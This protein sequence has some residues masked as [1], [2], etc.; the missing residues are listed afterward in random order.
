MK[1]ADGTYRAD[2]DGTLSVPSETPDPPRWLRT[3]A[4][5]IWPDIVSQLE[6]ID[7]LLAKVDAFALSRY[8]D[9]WIEYLDALREVEND[10]P[11]CVGEKGGMYPHPAVGRKNNAAK[12]LAQ[13]EAKFGMTASD[14]V[15]MKLQPKRHKGVRRRQA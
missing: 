2:R 3:E 11:T 6:P 5:E 8:C 7:G 9:D 13:F 1:I 12:R 4:R 15:G 14:R 10:G